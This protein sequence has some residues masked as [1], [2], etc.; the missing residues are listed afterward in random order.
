M[1]CLGL[2]RTPARDVLR[3][4]VETWL[5]VLAARPY[6]Q[7]RDTPRIRAAFA[8]LAETR[9]SWPQPVHFFEAMP[10][11]ITTAPREQP[12]RLSNDRICERGLMH[13]R[14]ILGEMRLDYDAKGNGDA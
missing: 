7:Q 8:K 12:K 3:G 2:D 1:L 10:N 9:D 11:P 14:A 4:T 6:E 13:T 5:Q